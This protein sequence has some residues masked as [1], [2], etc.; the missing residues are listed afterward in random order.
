M[1]LNFCHVLRRLTIY[2][3]IKDYPLALRRVVY[4]DEEQKREFVFLTN[5]THIT[6]LQVADLYKNR[7]QIELFFKWFKYNRKNEMCKN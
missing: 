3:S 5:A 7:W 1:F 4:W 2:K 6:A